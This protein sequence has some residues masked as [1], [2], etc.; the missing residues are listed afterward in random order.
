MGFHRLTVPTYYGGLPGSYDYI[1]NA[2]SGTP[3]PADGAKGSGVNAGTYFIAFGEDATSSNSNRANSALAENCDIL[4]D[5]F[6]TSSIV[7]RYVDVVATAAQV[8]FALTGDIYVGGASESPAVVNDQQTRNSLVHFVD[9]TTEDD[10]V[11]GGVTVTSSI[12]HDG[13]LVNVV[14]VPAD[15]FQTDPTVRSAVALPVGTTVRLYY[16]ERRSLADIIPNKPSEFLAQQMRSLEKIPAGLHVHGLDERYRRARTYDNTPPVPW[17][18]TAPVAGQAGSGAWIVKDG[19]PVTTYLYG[20]AL[21]GVSGTLDDRD[22]MCGAGWAH[23]HAQLAIPSS[24]ED[25]QCHGSGFVFLGAGRSARY[26]RSLYTP[27]LFGFM[28]A[29]K[30]DSGNPVTHTN[31]STVI[32]TA[33]TLNITGDTVTLNTGWFYK[34]LSGSD[35][36]SFARG[37][38]IIRLRNQTTGEYTEITVTT[39]LTATTGT[40]RYLDGSVPNLASTTFDIIGWVQPMYFSSE[41][42]NPY[43]DKIWTS[44]EILEYYGRFHAETP[45]SLSTDTYFTQRSPSRFYGGDQLGTTPVIV[46]GGYNEL[47]PTTVGA[48]YEGI[49]TLYADGSANIAGGATISNGLEVASGGVVITRSGLSS[50][51]LDI[52]LTGVSGNRDSRVYQHTTG[53]ELVYNAAWDEGTSLW[54][55]D[56]NAAGTHATRLRVADDSITMYSIDTNGAVPFG[57]AQFVSPGGQFQFSPGGTAPFVQLYSQGSGAAG[58]LFE[59]KGDG[60]SNDLSRLYINK[61]NP[62]ATASIAANSLYSKN[63]VKAWGQIHTDGSNGISIDGGF[64]IASVALV[65]SDP[66]PSMDITLTQPMSSTNELAITWGTASG[67]YFFQSGTISTSVIRLTPKSSADA[68]VNLGALVSDWH[69]IACY[70]E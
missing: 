44:S 15:G 12:I 16:F 29:A 56:S 63:I 38:D 18:G 53:V 33:D 28:H 11:I 9:S 64:G 20:S 60:T 48:R 47:D 68:A 27:S 54:T 43:F 10:L 41:N 66:Y 3:A 35:R 57:D 36:S 5:Y 30:R 67:S 42:P 17:P 6:R 13:S 24:D 58:V 31:D 39:F 22:Y 21:S 4:D 8:D 14:G 50:K 49:S 45:K 59:L 1:N 65:G 51:L 52:L 62:A 37:I 61:S 19:Y 55:P 34:N 70:A 25:R 23:E 32:E 40:A 69:F 7:M 2:I 46:W 26:D